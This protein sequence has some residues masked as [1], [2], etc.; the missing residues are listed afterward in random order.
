MNHQYRPGKHQTWDRGILYVLI[1]LSPLTSCIYGAPSKTT[2]FNVVYIFGNAE[3]RIFLLAA[4][5]CNP[6]WIL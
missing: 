3:S 2:S 6:E 1:H 4:Q 5:C